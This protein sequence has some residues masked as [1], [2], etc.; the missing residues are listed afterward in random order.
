MSENLKIHGM[1][2]YSS[3]GNDQEVRVFISFLKYLKDE[4]KR[5]GLIVFTKKPEESEW[6]QVLEDGT[7]ISLDDVLLA[8]Q[9]AI[10]ISVTF[11]DKIRDGLQALKITACPKKT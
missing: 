1:A 8:K 10:P 3:D 4:D 6:R 7:D 9:A 5:S 2:F 11:G